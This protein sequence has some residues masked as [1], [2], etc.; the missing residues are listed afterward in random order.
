MPLMTTLPAPIYTSW[1]DYLAQTTWAPVRQRCREIAKRAN[2]K[3]LL[4]PMPEHS[5]TRLIVW[6]VLSEARGRCA[7]CGSLAVERR[8]SDPRTGTPI[9]WEHVGRRIGSLKHKLAR[10]VGGDND[11]ANL[12]WCCLWCNTWPNER[13]PGAADHGGFYPDAR[14]DPD[15]KES[16]AILKDVAAARRM[17]VEQDHDDFDDDF[18]LLPDHECPE[19][20]AMWRQTFE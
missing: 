15:P 13:R 1:A 5:V 7:H 14:C 16:E 6:Q 19:A 9:T 11:L 4:S 17:S 3:R 12:A 18:E 20:T 8:P 10:Y 2:R